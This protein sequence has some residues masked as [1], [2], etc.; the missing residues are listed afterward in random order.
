M[1]LEILWIFRCEREESRVSFLDSCKQ[2]ELY[3]S[4]RVC[5]FV[6][7]KKEEKKR[8]ENSAQ[9]PCM[10]AMGLSIAGNPTP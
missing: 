7:E 8:R 10:C 4:N 3:Y 2:I 1:Y 5:G 9:N 6:Q